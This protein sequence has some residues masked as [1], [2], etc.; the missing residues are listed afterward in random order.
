MMEQ[1]S[2]YRR[3]NFIFKSEMSVQNLE[4]PTATSHIINS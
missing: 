2:V 3:N 1:K 4:R